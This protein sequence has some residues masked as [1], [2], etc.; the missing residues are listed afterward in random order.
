MPQ[1]IC[2][3]SAIVFGVN[4]DECTMPYGAPGNIHD[5]HKCPGKVSPV[6]KRDPSWGLEKMSQ[7]PVFAHGSLSIRSRLSG[8]GKLL[9][10]FRSMWDLLKTMALPVSS[11]LRITQHNFLSTY[12]YFCMSS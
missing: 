5:E 2:A 3:T 6:L 4:P 8:P 10:L 12:L 9:L 1:Y 11:G 7:Q